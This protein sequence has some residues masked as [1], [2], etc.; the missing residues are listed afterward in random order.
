VGSQ[1]G[2]SNKPLPQTALLYF[3]LVLCGAGVEAGVV[4]NVCSG[5]A[6]LQKI[7]MKAHVLT[8]L[9]GWFGFFCGIFFFFC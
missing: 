7:K 3:W 8:L 5:Q 4:R 1:V 6:N 2:F 9:L